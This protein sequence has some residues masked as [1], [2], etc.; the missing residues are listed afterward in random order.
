[1]SGVR[2]GK[3]LEEIR[4]DMREMRGEM[5]EMRGEIREALE[6]IRAERRFGHELL[7]RHELVMTDVLN[8]LRE[9]RAESRA[10]TQ[11]ILTLLD[12]LNGG[13]AAPAT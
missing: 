10:H 5:R 8:E 12:R 2:R 4:V 6:E 3:L 13:G 1:M 11:A 9:L 7:R